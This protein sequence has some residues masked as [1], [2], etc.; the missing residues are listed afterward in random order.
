M[1]SRRHKLITPSLFVVFHACSYNSSLEFSGLRRGTI[2]VCRSYAPLPR[3][4]AS[5]V[6]VLWSQ[7]GAS[8]PL[9][10]R[11]VPTHPQHPAESAKSR[12]FD[13]S[14]LP[15]SPTQSP[16]IVD[17]GANV[18]RRSPCL[19]AAVLA[20]YGSRQLFLGCR[21]S[22]TSGAG[23]VVGDLAQKPVAKPFDRLGIPGKPRVCGLIWRLHHL[24]LARCARTPATYGSGFCAQTSSQSC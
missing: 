19:G 12:P 5:V 11:R 10:R 22:V 4:T 17:S 8:Q 7:G 21:R 3:R 23:I 9:R 15:C 2:Q 13:M 24:G 14:F 18:C 20:L 6:P 16:T 1:V